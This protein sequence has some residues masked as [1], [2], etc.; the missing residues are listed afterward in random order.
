MFKKKVPIIDLSATRIVEPGSFVVNGNFYCML[1]ITPND[2]AGIAYTVFV[3]SENNE[4]VTFDNDKGIYKF[5][6][7]GVVEEAAED[8]DEKTKEELINEKIPNIENLPE[9]IRRLK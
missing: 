8:S 6:K 2:F 4:I 3:N 7:Q 9:E 1:S 5:V